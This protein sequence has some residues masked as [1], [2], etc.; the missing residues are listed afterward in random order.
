MP[1]EISLK[2]PFKYPSDREKREAIPQ[3]A[4]LKNEHGAAVLSGSPAWLFTRGAA[5]GKCLI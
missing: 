1:L 4:H 5:E 3:D 2:E